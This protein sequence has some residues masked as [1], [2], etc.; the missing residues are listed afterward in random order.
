MTACFPEAPVKQ[1]NSWMTQRGART[2]WREF[3][4]NC[5][6]RMI[7]AMRPRTVLVFGRKA[8]NAM[9]LDYQW[10]DEL[11]DSRGWLIYAR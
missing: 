1:S 4:T 10:C 5:V 7:L 2:D 6:R 8:S 9:G 3:S 11:L